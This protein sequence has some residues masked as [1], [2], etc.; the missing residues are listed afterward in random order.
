MCVLATG[1]RWEI[2]VPSDF[3]DEK[4]FVKLYVSENKSL[5]FSLVMCIKIGKLKKKLF[6]YTDM[7]FQTEASKCTN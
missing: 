2:S 3:V 4:R 7:L 1:L 5:P 6:C